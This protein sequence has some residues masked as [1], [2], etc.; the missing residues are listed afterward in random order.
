MNKQFRRDSIMRM[1]C[2]IHEDMRKKKKGKKKKKRA[3]LNDEN[4]TDTN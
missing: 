3:L 1:N 2:G 4:N